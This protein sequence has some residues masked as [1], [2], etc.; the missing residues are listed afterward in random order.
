LQKNNELPIHFIQHHKAHIYSV[1]AENDLENVLGVSFDG[2]GYGDDGNIWGG[3]FFIINNTESERF[4]HLNYVPM[5][6]GERAAKEPWRMA[7]IYLYK[8]YPEIVDSIITEKKFPQKD[9]I[10]LQ[11]LNDSVRLQTSSMGRFFDAVASLIDVCHF[12]SYEGEAP[13]KL[14]ALADENFSEYYHFVLINKGHL[15]KLI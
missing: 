14:E 6:S 15:L 5:I 3:E 2:T 9:M 11:L 13:M 8:Y 12:N 4:A 10:I 1:M 7:L